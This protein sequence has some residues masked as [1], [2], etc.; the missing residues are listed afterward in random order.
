MKLHKILVIA[1]L[2]K[3]QIEPALERLKRWAA[4]KKIEVLVRAG[5]DSTP[6]LETNLD[7]VVT[8]G[9]DGTLLKGARR[10]AAL[11]LP[12]LGINLGSLGFLT[13]A[14]VA[15]LESAFERVLADNFSVEMRMRLEAQTLSTTSPNVPW[16]VLN[17]IGLVHAEITRRTEIELFLGERALG[18]YPGD[19]LLISTPTGSTAYA[20]SAGGPI[21]EPTMECLLVTPLSPHR[22][23]L[24]PLVLPAESV[25]LAVA[26]RPVQLLA[27]GDPAGLLDS[28]MTVQIRKAPRPTRL[29]KLTPNPDFLTAW[30]RLNWG[31]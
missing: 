5:I 28:D 9:G 21:L 14:G 31:G 17:E 13:S 29:V 20:L 4:L 7:L 23:G 19:G 1:N 3:P 12:V 30:R 11:D 8:L 10:A 27:D 18:C 15:E 2:A 16:N 25:L 6:V 24:R 22:L 26:K